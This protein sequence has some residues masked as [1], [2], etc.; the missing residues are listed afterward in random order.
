MERSH[1]LVIALVVAALGLFGLRLLS[2]PSDDLQTASL[3]RS[4]RLGPDGMPLDG[5]AGGRDGRRGRL[6]DGSGGSGGDHGR[7]SPGGFGSD[8]GGAS[9]GANRGAA[10][11]VMGGRNHAGG[12]GGAVGGG[13]GGASGGGSTGSLASAGSAGQLGPKAERRSDLVESLG[14]RPPTKSDLDTA[15]K[16]DNGDGVTLKLDKPE[17]IADQGGVAKD[18][19]AP[20]DSDDGIQIPPDG[21]VQLPPGAISG[22]GGTV[23]FTVKPDW[24]GSDP[25]DNALLEYRQEHEWSNRME[26]VKNGD[27]LRFILTDSGGKETDISTKIDN[28]QAGDEH[29][30]SASWDGQSKTTYLYVDG[31]LAGQN[32]YK[33]PYVPPSTNMIVGADHSSGAYS[34]LSGT[35]RGFQVSS[36]PQHP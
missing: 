24:A 8:R 21:R 34:G 13:S 30:I 6:G 32:Q 22:D 35:L 36:S 5:S 12:L 17:D 2:T 7:L 28:W 1:F 11:T 23:S 31:Q 18:V 3:G 33:D 14:S 10:D 20:K 26:I 29:A 4:E 15:P 19:D 16:P 9:G 27:F 25:G